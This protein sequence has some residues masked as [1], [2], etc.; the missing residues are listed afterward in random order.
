MVCLICR[1][2]DQELEIVDLVNKPR[3][4]M[5]VGYLFDSDFQIRFTNMTYLQ[6]FKIGVL[7]FFIFR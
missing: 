5:F 6:R 7:T 1:V 3:G 4:D 2:G